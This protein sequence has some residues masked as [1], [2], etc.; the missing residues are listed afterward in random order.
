M[1]TLPR[2]QEDLGGAVVLIGHDMGLMAQFVER[3]G[4]MYRGG[5]VEVGRSSNLCRDAASD[6]RMLMESLHSFDR[7]RRFPRR[8]CPGH[9]PNSGDWALLGFC[10]I[11]E[12][13]RVRLRHRPP[14][15]ENRPQ[16]HVACP[17]GGKL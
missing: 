15:P 2:V 16:Q 9:F 13:E 12:A 4:V 3:L 14:Q 11:R 7:P 8:Q 5:S 17:H 6:T 1:E 10:E